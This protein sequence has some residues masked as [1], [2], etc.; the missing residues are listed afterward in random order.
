[1]V[2]DGEVLGVHE[3]AT[4]QAFQD[5][6]SAFGRDGA[7]GAAARLLVRFFDV[8][9]RDGVDLIDEPLDARQRHL[10][11]VVGE[12]AIPRVAPP[13][14]RRRRRCSTTRSPRATRAPW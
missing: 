12:L 1:M 4:P 14:R 2:L 10:D 3:D 6:M 11:E 7:S 9:H 13:T 5:T 8:L